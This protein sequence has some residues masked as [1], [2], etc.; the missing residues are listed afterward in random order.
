MV[1]EKRVAHKSF[2]RRAGSERGL[3]GISAH[4]LSCQSADALAMG[5]KQHTHK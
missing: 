1:N 2:R 3:R 5:M 4:L